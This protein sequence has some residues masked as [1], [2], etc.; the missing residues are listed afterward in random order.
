[1]TPHTKIAPLSEL[2]QKVAT[3]TYALHLCSFHQTPS[4]CSSCA[5]APAVRPT[6]PS[7]PHSAE[8]HH[9]HHRH[10]PPAPTTPMSGDALLDA[11]SSC[12][13]QSRENVLDGLRSGRVAGKTPPQPHSQP[14]QPQPHQPH[15]TRGRAR[16]PAAW[17]GRLVD[18]CPAPANHPK[19]YALPVAPPPP[20]PPAAAAAGCPRPFPARQPLPWS[21]SRR[22][23]L[24]S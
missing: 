24:A 13:Q 2:F 14:P 5:L 8:Q 22:P 23:A 17:E 15:K 16:R 21:S 6:P 11:P 3:T 12:R 1:M 19:R 18:D 9:Q 20:P 10:Q 4:F 7:S